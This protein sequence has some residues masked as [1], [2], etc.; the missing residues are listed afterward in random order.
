MSK[1]PRFRTPFSNQHPKGCQTLLKTATQRFY[2]MFSLLSG[3]MNWEIS[4]LVIFEILE[5]FVNTLTADD[6]YYLRKREKILL[7]IQRQ[8]TKKKK[9]WFFCCISEIYI[10]LW[11]FW[12]NRMPVIR[13]RRKTSLDKCLKNLVLEHHLTVNMRKGP[14]HSWNMHHSTFIIFFITLREIE[15]EDVS[16]IDIWN[17]RTD[18]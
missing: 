7:P 13:E 4:L 16:L 8:I 9:S 12:K 6:K 1:L 17:L 15:F 11:T 2:H 18:C 5:P 10:I 14:K 3:K